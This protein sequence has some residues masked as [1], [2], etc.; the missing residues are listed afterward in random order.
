MGENELAGEALQERAAEL[1][2][3]GRSS[4]SADELREAVAAKEAE[5][6]AGEGPT[7]GGNANTTGD[8]PDG[9]DPH[10]DVTEAAEAAAEA[11]PPHP[12]E[13]TMKERVALL[14]YA[15]EH[16]MGINLARLAEERGEVT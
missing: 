2:I 4:M 13:G 3:E 8:Q 10:P 15:V 12:S 9:E 5:L 14:E 16:R 7:T 6:A 1:E 11:A